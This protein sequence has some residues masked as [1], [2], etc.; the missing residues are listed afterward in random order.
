MTPHR[1]TSAQDAPAILTLIRA[2]F[3]YMDG[4]IDP[5]SSMHLLTAAEIAR[6]I[7]TAEVWAIGTPPLACMILT[8]KGDWLYL[9]KLAVAHDLR[10]RGLARALVATA[11]QRAATLG[12]RG[13]E[14]HTRI[15]L[16]AN[17]ATFTA[18]GFHETA[19]SAHPG[20]DRP[21][22]LTFRR[23]LDPK[24]PPR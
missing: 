20:Y 21:T 15:E 23:P 18:L 17:H 5:P 11:M 3:A 1:V 24:E 7:A 10:G 12:L 8:P 4:V 2:A 14:L 6:Q 16:L 13:V 22:S 9:G 19:R